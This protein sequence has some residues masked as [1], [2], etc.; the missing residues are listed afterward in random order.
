MEIYY[1]SNVIN[2]SIKRFLI[3]ILSVQFAVWGFIGLSYLNINVP[4][5]RQIICFMYLIFI[6]GILLLRLLNIKNISNIEYLLFIMALSLTLLMCLGF[7]MNLLCPL[8][9]INNPLTETLLIFGISLIVL[10]LCSFCYYREKNKNYLECP[11]KQHFQVR[12]LL[13]LILPLLCLIGVYLFNFYYT[14]SILILVYL[15]IAILIIYIGINKQNAWQDYYPLVII[16]ISVSLLYSTSLISE[17]I[18]GWDIFTEFYFA[19][20]VIN[21]SF[22]DMTVKSNVNTM[23]SIVMLGP[24]FSKI[25]N[26][27]LVWALKIIYPL[28]FSIVPLGLYEVYRKQTSEKLAFF[29]SIYFMF[30][31]TYFIDM[32]DKARQQI[33]EFFLVA[34]LLLIINKEIDNRKKSIL[35]ILF[36]F[37]LIVS[38]YAL[39][40]IFIFCLVMS[41]IMMSLF[42]KSRIKD[43]NDKKPFSSIYVLIFIVLTITW[44]MYISGSSAFDTIINI[45]SIII[46]NIFTEFL[47]PNTIQ[48]LNIAVTKLPLMH[49]ITKILNILTQFCICIGIYFSVFKNDNNYKFTKEYLS[50]AFAG[51]LICIFCLCVPFFSQQLQTSRFYHITQI[52]LAP[53]CIIGMNELYNPIAKTVGLKNIRYAMISIFF[54]LFLLFNCGLV[55]KVA[56]EITNSASLISWDPYYDYARF[57]K[58]EVKGAKWLVEVRGNKN[59]YADYFRWMLFAGF[60]KEKI[61]D[62]LNLFEQ[63]TN[64]NLN[65]NQSTNLLFFGSTNVN[66]KIIALDPN[67]YISARSVVLDC[68]RVYD[69]KRAQIYLR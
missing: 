28:I 50:F 51:L 55:Y 17:Y 48:G 63:D 53:F 3:I 61:N 26:M 42:N 38:H 12:S 41:W 31:F 46:G 60:D 34:L 20:K 57:N 68:S 5:V 36:G 19:N 44:Y 58:C 64:L 25:C 4:L 29:G 59:V 66:K 49:E 18:W 45:G 8:F 69:N 10:I 62:Y 47:N 65:I 14:N 32:A 2:C 22:W 35:L 13:I 7:L 37:S 40:Y 15:F 67:K 56:G 16:A 39:S 27:D 52:F 24:I 23:L 9:G 43:F 33:G 21:N 54:A 6:P 1:L 30:T 11:F